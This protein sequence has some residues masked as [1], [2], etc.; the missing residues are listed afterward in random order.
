MLAQDP[1]VREEE[2]EAVHNMRSATRRIRSVLAA[3]RKLYSAGPV[4][5]LR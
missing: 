4:R 5:R 3:Y 1:A 2:P